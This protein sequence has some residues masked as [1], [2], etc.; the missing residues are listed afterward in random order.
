MYELLNKLIQII[1]TNFSEDF[2]KIENIIKCNELY[3]QLDMDEQELIMEEAKEEHQQ[4]C[5][6]KKNFDSV[7]PSYRDV[8]SYMKK[9]NYNYGHYT[10]APTLVPNNEGKLLTEGEIMSDRVKAVMI[11]EPTEE[12]FKKRADIFSDTKIRSVNMPAQKSVGWHAMRR[13]RIG[14]SECGTV[15]NMNKHQSQYTFILDKVLGAEFKGNAATYHGN[16]FEDVVRMIYE[17]NNDVHTEEFSS[18]PH[19]TNS[20]LAASPDGIVSPYCRD[21]ITPTKLVGRMLEIKCPTMRRIQYSGDI[22]DTICPVY[23]WCQIQQQLECLDL[24]EC[25]FIQCN[26]ERYG[27]RQEWLAD[28]HP[29]CNFKSAKYGNPRGI[30][31]ELIPSKLSEC[32]YNEKGFYSDMTVWA[33]TK[34][35]F[36]EKIDLTCKE[37]D[38]W[39]LT[40]L[41]NLPW[42]YTL[43]KIIYWRLVEQNCTLI[44][45]NKEWFASQLPLYNRIWN[46][47]AYL[48]ENLDVIEEWKQW[49]GLQA[50]KYN[51]KIMTKLDLLIE[52]KE[53][54]KLTPNLIEQMEPDKSNPN[55]S[56]IKVVKSSKSSK[57]S[58]SN[59]HGITINLDSDSDIDEPKIF[60]KE[61]IIQINSTEI[62]NTYDN[63]EIVEQETNIIGTIGTNGTNG[64]NGT[65]G[66]S[67][68]SDKVTRKYIRKVK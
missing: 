18:M 51:D 33:K 5:E 29:Q 1:K 17:Y 65:I 32:D 40:Q 57:S 22:K 49:I 38:D 55:I 54:S 9:N 60:P 16:V 19:K 12:E 43:H 44:L 56:D 35:L 15:L 14:G 58:K 26:I 3:N 2:N 36:P 31:I 47:V 62:N 25:D 6:D 24:D 53:K 48:R 64:T 42:G 13:N 68:K 28:T 52:Q 39:I 41:D 46:Y 45:R 67:D 11:K 20:I 30:A 37:L 21:M 4:L 27:S 7:K 50:R 61:K 34:C 59:N 66:T 8:K 10:P 63:L 23:Y